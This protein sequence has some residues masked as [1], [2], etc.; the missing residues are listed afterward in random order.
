MPLIDRIYWA[1]IGA[2]WLALS[3]KLSLTMLATFDAAQHPIA[4]PFELGL[5]AILA[6]MLSGFFVAVPLK[7]VLNLFSAERRRTHRTQ[8]AALALAF[9]LPVG[10]A[11]EA[12]RESAAHT[13][14]EGVTTLAAFAERMPAP[15]QVHSFR[16]GGKLYI[17]WT[18]KSAGPLDITSGPPCY[19]FNERGDLE[20]WVAQTGEGTQVDKL[21]GTGQFRRELTVEQALEISRSAVNQEAAEP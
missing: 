10:F 2:S 6:A 18:T 17:A 20:L 7:V 11:A 3:V 13:P 14:P 21:L 16:S 4:L 8:T 15:T 19:L 9:I 12:L 5:Q 1:A